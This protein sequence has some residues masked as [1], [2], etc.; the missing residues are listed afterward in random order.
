MR[1]LWVIHSHQIDDLSADI[2]SSRLRCDDLV[3][4]SDAADLPHARPLKHAKALLG[5]TLPALIFDAR[6]G[7]ALDYFL[8]AAH[9]I[10]DQGALIIIAP[11]FN[12]DDPQSLRFHHTS[13]PTPHFQQHLNACL[14][15][16]AQP[17]DLDH[18]Q[19]NAITATDVML[20]N[21]QQYV[22]TQLQNF[23]TGILTLFAPRG[24]GKSTVIAHFL[25]AVDN[26]VLTAP[27]QP[28]LKRYAQ[29][30]DN[31]KAPD[32][33]FLNHAPKSFEWLIIEEAAQMPIAHLEKL[34]ALAHKVILISSVDNYEGT[35]QGLAQK[36]H[37]IL[38]IEQALTLTKSQRFDDQDPLARFCQAIA[39]QEPCTESLPEGL[40]LYDHDGLTALQSQSEYIQALYQ[41]L[42]THH[43]QTNAQ[44]VRRL[45][46]GH[47]QLFITDVQNSTLHGAIWALKE[48]ELSTDLAVDIFNGYRR[49][50]GNLVVQTLGAHSYYPE[51][52]TKKSLRVSRIAVDH[53]HRHQGIASNMLMHLIE[54]AKVHQYDFISTSFGLTED[55]LSFWQQA[56]FTWVHMGTHR[57]KTTG[58]H[59]A[60]LLYPLTD[61]MQTLIERMAQKWRADAYHL[62]DAPFVHTSVHPCLQTIA[63]PAPFDALDIKILT[64]HQQ[65]KKPKEAVFS[66][67]QRQILKND[68]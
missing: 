41:F 1:A 5:Q 52:M 2:I 40:N 6:D 23:S 17:F 19:H 8:C 22:I 12:G 30:V 35:G 36:L 61:A 18:I 11:H 20:T 47:N 54:Y 37:A 10:E 27:N 15:R 4:L 43:Y 32:D 59:A 68:Q 13:I 21:E 42:N 55:L 67:L 62:L 29:H 28:S 38:P 45:F 33:L 65:H 50:K 58:L 49:P 44:D 31:F 60:I 39:L 66:A 64:A 16:Y 24:T 7:F 34:S 9:T 51:L 25:Q 63:K 48:G 46:D 3:V 26:F 57:D 56:D 53:A 14:A